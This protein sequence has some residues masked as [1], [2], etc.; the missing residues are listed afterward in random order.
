MLKRKV[1]VIMVKVTATAADKL[2]EI[3]SKEHNLDTTLVRI[4]LAGVG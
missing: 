1:G 3:I 2:K 4:Y